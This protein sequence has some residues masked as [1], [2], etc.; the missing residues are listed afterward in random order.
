M[1][2]FGMLP[3]ELLRSVVEHLKDQKI[4]NFDIV[5]TQD[6]QNLRLTCMTLRTIV[7]LILFE[8]MVLEFRLWEPGDDGQ[9]RL[10]TFATLSFIHDKLVVAL[11]DW[12]DAEFE[13]VESKCPL[14]RDTLRR[15]PNLRHVEHALS[16]YYLRFIDG[17][18][19][20][21]SCIFATISIPDAF[22]EGFKLIVR[23]LPDSITSLKLRNVALSQP[24]PSDDQ[25]LSATLQHLDLEL[26]IPE[27]WD[28]ESKPYGSAFVEAWRRNLIH[29]VRLK[30]LRLSFE[31]G[32]GRATGYNSCVE[33][34]YINDLLIDPTDDGKFIV[35]PHLRSLALTNCSLGICEFLAFAAAR[36]PTLK[37]LELSR[38]TFD[39]SYCPSS[40]SEIAATCKNALPNLT[41]LRLAKLI[42]HFARRT[43]APVEEDAAPERWN[44]GLEAETAYEWCKRIHGPD[45]EVKGSKC[46]WEAK[47]VIVEEE[48]KR[49]F[50][51]DRYWFYTEKERALRA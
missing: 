22:T 31:D 3:N 45:V 14:I 51:G 1:A 13:A 6:L 28:N 48:C 7:T 20:E 8:N 24:Y 9:S 50:N 21:I 10:I 38:V 15:L 26:R 4:D 32:Q 29:L 34:K 40:W 36:S 43:D 18:L 41:Y 16:T 27:G 11:Q 5:A 23:D 49:N 33:P 44:R 12:Q 47:D 19:S 2:S 17:I 39:P 37:E 30:T 25:G 42:T 46:S 35:F